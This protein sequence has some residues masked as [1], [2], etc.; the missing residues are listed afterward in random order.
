[1]AKLIELIEKW[2]L[3]FDILVN[4]R[5]NFEINIIRTGIKDNW[6]KYRFNQDFAIFAFIRKKYLILIEY[7]LNK[8]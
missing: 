8:I 4:C 3:W 2:I 1:M 6:R 5:S 7:S